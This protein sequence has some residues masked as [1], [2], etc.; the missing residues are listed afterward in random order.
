MGLLLVYV[1]FFFLLSSGASNYHM[2]H[3][4]LSSLESVHAYVSLRVSVQ[5]AFIFCISLVYLIHTIMLWQS[6]LVS[7]YVFLY[8]KKHKHVCMC[9]KIEP[10]PSRLAFQSFCPSPTFAPATSRWVVQVRFNFC[11]LVLKKPWIQLLLS[12]YIWNYVVKITIIYY[13]I[14]KNEFTKFYMNFLSGIA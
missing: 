2:M 11:S 1:T 3:C 12:V 10:H 9:C 14:G 8:I 4:R 13:Q 7:V 6:L 5:A